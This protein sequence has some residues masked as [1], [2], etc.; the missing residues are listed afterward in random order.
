MM[1][2]WGQ[3]VRRSGEGR[4]TYLH[5]CHYDP[6]VRPTNGASSWYVRACVSQRTEVALG[7]TQ[8]VR[9]LRQIARNAC[10]TAAWVP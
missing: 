3:V 2:P 7:Q 10:F 8:R 5:E 4:C 1:S 6:A 9:E